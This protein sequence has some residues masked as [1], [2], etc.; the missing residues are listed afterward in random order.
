MMTTQGNNIDSIYSQNV[1]GL[2]HQ[3]FG[4][5]QPPEIPLN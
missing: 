3:G 2:H 5:Y 1:P 4:A